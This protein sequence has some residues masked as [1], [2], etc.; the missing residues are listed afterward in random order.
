MNIEI[1]K[2][3]AQRLGAGP[4]PA[5]LGDTPSG[6]AAAITLILARNPRFGA[7][8]CGACDRDLTPDLE[9]CPYCGH[10]LIAKL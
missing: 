1:M 5:R 3:A 4:P 9:V 8:A 2:A 6:W 10:D 7:V